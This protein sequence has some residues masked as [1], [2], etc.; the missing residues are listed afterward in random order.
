MARIYGGSNGMDFAQLR[1]PPAQID[2]HD[3]TADGAGSSRRRFLTRAG[4]AV[5]AGT[6]ALPLV[7]RVASA[8]QTDIEPTAAAEATAGATGGLGAEA[9]AEADLSAGAGCT[10]DPIEL[11]AADLAIVSFHESLELAAVQLYEA[12]VA[13]GRLRAQLLE[14]ARSFGRH[15]RAHAEALYCMAGSQAPDGERATANPQVLDSLEPQIRTALDPESVM[16]PLYELEE[17]L[18]ATNV[19][20]LGQIENPSAAGAVAS[21]LPV[22]AQQATVWGQALDLPIQDWMP[23]FQSDAGAYTP[24][25]S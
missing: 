2:E 9:P 14:H 8:Q 6:A 1:T 18:A 12:A 24:A 17:S 4:T 13:S 16:R 15:H 25:D 19:A 3:P 5:V 11:S 21:I 20:A 22:D 23:T 7:A 10:T